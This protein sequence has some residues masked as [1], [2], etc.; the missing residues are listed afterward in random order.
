MKNVFRKNTG[1]SKINYIST[2]VDESWMTYQHGEG[3][4]GIENHGRSVANR[5]SQETVVIGQRSGPRM[6]LIRPTLKRLKCRTHARN[7]N[8]LPFFFFS[9]SNAFSPER[10]STIL[11]RHAFVTT[12]QKQ[13]R[14]KPNS[15]IADGRSGEKGPCTQKHKGSLSLARNLGAVLKLTF[16]G[17]I[18]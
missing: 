8:Q 1:L 18:A 17:E 16:S 15:K 12:L 4:D 10:P 11:L 5:F 6:G 9:A 7:Q 14:A 13:S 2:I 3:E